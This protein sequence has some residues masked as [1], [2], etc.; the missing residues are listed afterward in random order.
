MW[1]YTAN[2]TLEV[3]GT[4]YVLE[5]SGEAKKPVQVMARSSRQASHWDMISSSKLQ[6]ASKS[7]D[8]SKLCLDIDSRGLIIT[9]KCKCPDSSDPTCDPSSQW[10]KLVDSTTSSV[11]QE[12][13]LA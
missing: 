1:T 11:G 7:K 3:T 8:G 10:F 2:K 5:S 6:L 4:R 12:D 9:E 13:S